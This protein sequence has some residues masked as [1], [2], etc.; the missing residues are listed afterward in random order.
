M[1]AIQMHAKSCMP[2][3]MCA[4]INDLCH[5][6]SRCYRCSHMKPHSAHA[7]KHLVM[8]MCGFFRKVEENGLK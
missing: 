1:H 2:Q 7:C 3:Y 6:G 8:D 4:H 5:V